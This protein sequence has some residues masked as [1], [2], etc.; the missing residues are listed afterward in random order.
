MLETAWGAQR[1]WV[2]WQCEVGENQLTNLHATPQ[3]CPIAPFMLCLWVASGYK[4]HERM[5]A[6]GPFEDLDVCYL[7][8]R[9]W[10][11]K[12]AA[13]VVRKQGFW[14]QWSETVKLREN[15]GKSMWLLKVLP[16]ARIS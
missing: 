2:K 13:E 1:R 10:C 15:L 3:G 4:V 11:S 12:K 9:S 5:L 8:D 7:D 16:T 6:T 14:A